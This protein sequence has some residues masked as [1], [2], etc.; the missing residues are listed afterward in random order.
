MYNSMLKRRCAHEDSLTPVCDPVFIHETLHALGLGYHQGGYKC[1]ASDIKSKKPWRECPYV[2]YGGVLDALG[3]ASVSAKAAFGAAAKNRWQLA[4]LQHPRDVQLVQANATVQIMPLGAGLPK[5]ENKV[6]AVVV[7]F[8]KVWGGRVQGTGDIWLEFRAPYGYDN[9]SGVVPNTRNGQG[10]VA[11]QWGTALI[12]L[13]PDAGD[14]RDHLNVALR[15]GSSWWV[16]RKSGLRLRT[17][18]VPTVTRALT[19][20][21]KTNT[22]TNTNPHPSTNPLPTVNRPLR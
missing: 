6:R 14:P 8:D 9:M 7:R 21:L 13:D 17:I 3:S 1:T 4:W 10:L 12:D 2:E 11:Y 18:Q 15:A 22:N 20:T 16:D 19:L 5:G